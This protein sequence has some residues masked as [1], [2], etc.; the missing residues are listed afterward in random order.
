MTE[1]EKKIQLSKWAYFKGYICTCNVDGSI[2]INSN[3]VM[4][5]SLT[6]GENMDKQAQSIVLMHNDLLD[7]LAH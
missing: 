6:M 4:D 2:P 3:V 1:S 5:L 7:H